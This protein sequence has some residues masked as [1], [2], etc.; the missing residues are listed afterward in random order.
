MRVYIKKDLPVR[1]RSCFIQVASPELLPK[2]LYSRLAQLSQVPDYRNASL[3]HSID[4]SLG[5]AA[6]AADDC[7]GVAHS[8]A[9]RRGEPGYKTNDRLAHLPNDEFSRILLCRPANL[10]NHHYPTGGG[11]CLEQLQSIDEVRANDRITTDAYT[12]ALT[13]AILGQL[14]HHLV[15]QS[16]AA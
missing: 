5:R 12:G 7:S 16:A 3:F 2:N 1:D 11:I 10:S 15:G 4:F 13:H 8:P 9:R 14:V 6:G